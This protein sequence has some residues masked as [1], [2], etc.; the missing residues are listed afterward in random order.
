MGTLQQPDVDTAPPWTTTLMA[1]GVLM[2]V[3]VFWTL[4]QRT[5]L[6]YTV[7]FRWFALFAFAGNLLPVPWAA[8]YLKMDRLDWF[9]FN[10]TAVGP[11]LLSALLA[12]NFLCHGPERMMLVRQGR[13]LDLH[14]YWRE[15]RALPPHLPWPADFGRDPQKDR[16]ALSTVEPGDVVYGLAE[17]CL[18]YLVITDVTDARDLYPDG[19]E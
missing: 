9:W 12:L 3:V 11:V 8:R 4:G 6:T 16:F 10:L 5:L 7:F 13:G 17:G 15:Q 1:L 2:L 14:A 18:G 19:K